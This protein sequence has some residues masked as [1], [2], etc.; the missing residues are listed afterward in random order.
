MLYRTYHLR[1]QAV[2]LQVNEVNMAAAVSR[3]TGDLKV[4][5]EEATQLL[6]R[7]FSAAMDECASLVSVTQER[8]A[9]ENQLLAGTVAATASLH[10][11]VSE[12]IDK[13]LPSR[14]ES[15]VNTAMTQVTLEFGKLEV[16]LAKQVQDVNHAVA[17]CADTHAKAERSL[18]KITDSAKSVD[19]V[20]DGLRDASK[21]LHTGMAELAGTSLPQLQLTIEKL[22]GHAHTISK[23]IQAVPDSLA[24]G[25]KAFQQTAADSE[26]V[27]AALTNSAHLLEVASQRLDASTRVSADRLE[28]ASQA[29][30][31]RML[32]VTVP[33]LQQLEKTLADNTASLRRTIDTLAQTTQPAASIVA[34]A[35]KLLR[36]ITPVF[37]DLTATLTN[38]QMGSREVLIAT[39]RQAAS[40]KS[41]ST[42]AEDLPRRLE[43]R[44]STSIDTPLQ[45]LANVVNG[46]QRLVIALESLLQQLGQLADSP[47][48]PGTRS[49]LL[50]LIRRG[51]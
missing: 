27:A 20:V 19:G 17:Q 2:D 18:K 44:L 22:T 4:Q 13:L 25:V 10:E 31:Q 51:R 14:M 43:T 42:V 6:K 50:D 21:T 41:W 3:A 34:N 47:R 40:L 36:D 9:K 5:I 1:R 29:T 39:E 33:M 24:S 28:T 30:E 11:R 15:A 32:T 35:D 37:T 7:R 38:L 46:T 45:G 49:G 8:L 48:Q 23:A 12:F 16:A 26:T